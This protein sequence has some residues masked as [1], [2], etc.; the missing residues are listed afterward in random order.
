M[1]SFI[2][3]VIGL[4]ASFSAIVGCCLLLAFFGFYAVNNHWAYAFGFLL[5]PIWGAAM[6]KVMDFA[7]DHFDPI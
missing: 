1:R 7:I 3:N 6:M 5:I 4:T 2:G